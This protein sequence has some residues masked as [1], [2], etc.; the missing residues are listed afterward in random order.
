MSESD[1]ITLEVWRPIPMTGC[2]YAASSLGRIRGPRG[3][4]LIAHPNPATRYLTVAA[5]RES[6]RPFTCCVHTL[7]ADAFLGPR[8]DGLDVNHKN[9]QRHDNRPENLEYA[10]RSENISHSYRVLNRAPVLPPVVRGERH[11]NA[12]LT[13][14][15]VQEVRDTYARLCVVRGRVTKAIRAMAVDL[16]VSERSLWTFIRGTRRRP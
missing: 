8:P 13:D 5:R 2:L 7:V 12:K 3:R 9:G 14:A 10:T 15:Q 11:A 6:N 16:G 1:S 4:V